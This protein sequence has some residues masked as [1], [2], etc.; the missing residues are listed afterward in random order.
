MTGPS[1][2][3]NE[4]IYEI[5]VGTDPKNDMRFTVGKVYMRGTENQMTVTHIAFDQNMLVEYGRTRA[6]VY[7]KNR[8]GVEKAW[9][10]LI[11]VPITITSKV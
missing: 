10:D 6:I 5:T 4:N 8:D 2:I 9:K 3:D 11:D 1:F 7:G